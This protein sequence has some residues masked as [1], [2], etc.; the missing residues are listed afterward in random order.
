MM[1]GYPRP[2]PAGRLHIIFPI[3]FSR[4]TF[5]RA[6]VWGAIV[7]FDRS[8]RLWHLDIANWNPYKQPADRHDTKSAYKV[9]GCKDVGMG[10]NGWASSTYLHTYELS[11]P[12]PSTGFGMARTSQLGRSTGSPPRRSTRASMPPRPRSFRAAGSPDSTRVPCI[13]RRGPAYN[14]TAA[15]TAVPGTGTPHWTQAVRL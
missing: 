2:G 13:R 7:R 12:N 4:S 5:S 9:R 15:F 11:Y 6:P 8:R 10:A 3:T 14:R 1:S